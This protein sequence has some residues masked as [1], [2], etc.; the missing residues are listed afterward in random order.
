MYSRDYRYTKEHEWIKV[1]GKRGVVG[2]TDYAQE[3]L[4]DIVYVELPKVGRHL[5]AMESFGT[6]ESVKAVSDIYSPVAG[7]VTEVNAVLAD[8][9]AWVNEDPHGK[10]WLAKLELDDPSSVDHLLTA[11]EYEKFIREEAKT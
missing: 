4:G 2:I 9:P 7:T 6:V 1:E 10:A 3:K 5:N 11:E 8:N